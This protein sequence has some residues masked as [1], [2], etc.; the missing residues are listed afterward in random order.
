MRLQNDKAAGEDRIVA[1]LLKSGRDTVIDWLT[2][3][4]Q[5]VWRTRKVPQDWRN[6]TLIPLFKKKNRTQCNNYRGISLLSVPGKV[7][8]LILLGWLHSIIDPQLMETQCGFRKGRGTVDQIWVVRQVFERATECRTLVFMC[9][10]DLTKAYDSVN[11]Q[12]MAAILREYG[13]PRQLVAII[14]EL[15]SE[16]W[17]QVRSAGETSERFE[18]RTRVHQGCVLSSLSFNCFLDKILREVMA[19]LNGGLHIDYTTSE[20]VFLTYRDKTTE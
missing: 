11:R 9:F 17:C 5:E 20:V 7:L 6:A 13:V 19:T 1:E 2:E 8:T 14:E 12:A 16:T 18:V 3:L 4:M 10:V 15:H